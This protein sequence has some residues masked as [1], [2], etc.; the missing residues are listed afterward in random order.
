LSSQHPDNFAGSLYIAERTSGLLLLML[1]QILFVV[2]F[3]QSCLPAKSRTAVVAMSTAAAVAAERLAMSEVPLPDMSSDS[4]SDERDYVNPKD[5]KRPISDE[6][7]LRHL[8][9]MYE[10]IEDLSDSARERIVAKLPSTL[11]KYKV[12]PRQLHT[13]LCK[14]YGAALPYEFGEWARVHSTP[15]DDWPVAVPSDPLVY[16][17][18]EVDGQPFLDRVVI[19]LFASVVPRTAENFRQLCVGVGSLGYK[20]SRIH[21][22]EKDQL[23]Q[24]GDITM[25]DGRGG[26]SIYGGFG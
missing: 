1:L 17:R 10:R 13:M 22:T 11:A 7:V 14:K 15:T 18:F 26:A 21:R 12:F 6:K 9:Q 24:G 19:Q 25:G 3:H 4:E 20:F 23:I 2:F 8:V 16:L 5:K